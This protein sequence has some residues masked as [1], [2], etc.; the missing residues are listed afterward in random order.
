M[1]AQPFKLFFI[2]KYLA[3]IPILGVKNLK[4]KKMLLQK[5]Y[6]NE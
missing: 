3:L 1:L 5:V 2:V 6:V 4:K